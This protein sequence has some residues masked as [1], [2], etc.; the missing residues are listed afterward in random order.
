MFEPHDFFWQTPAMYFR[1]ALPALFA[2]F[3]LVSGS[4]CQKSESPA[5][6]AP[7]TVQSPDTIAWAHWVGKRRL[8]MEADSYYFSRVWSLPETARLQSQT[9]D[10]LAIGSWRLL[11]GEKAQIPGAVLRPLFDD[12]AQEE[13]YFEIRAASNSPANFLLAVHVNAHRAG[14]WETNLAI[15]ASLVTGQGP[16]PNPA[17]HGWTLQQTNAP[18]H[19]FLSRVGDWTLVAAGPG[20]NS[21]SDEIAARIRRDG[22]PFVSSGTN[23]WLETSLDLPRLAACFPALNS[24]L[25]TLN[26]LSFS[27]TGDGANVITRGQLAFSEPLPSPLAPWQMPLD[28]LHDPLTGFTAVRGLQPWLAAWQPWHDLQIGAP[29]D[30]LFLWS[31][32]GSPYQAYLAAPL[33]DAEVS[34]L[35]TWLLQKANPWLATNGY[36]TFARAADANG[37]TWGALPDIKPF[38]KSSGAGSNHWLFAGLLP[39]PRT[40]ADPPPQGLID[41]VLHRPDLVYYDWE[42]TGIRMEPDLVLGQTVRQV[43]HGTPMPMTS[44][45]LG[46]L[47]VLIPRLGTS[48]TIA[49]RTAPDQIDFYRRS[50]LGLTATELHLLADWL[51]SPQF[52]RGLHSQ[53]IP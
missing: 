15:A 10:R 8:D 42:V 52:P 13:C 44:A 39:D 12:L 38:I 46:W 35:T 48:A 2:V 22:V 43:A 21:L 24:Q 49:T 19:I 41:D 37:V 14:L 30:Q 34:A 53:S 3:I 1:P 7:P 23:L 50:T 9:F 40:A 20:Q 18:T 26:H 32:A 16:T 4:G 31:V 45:S 33:P 11:L 5:A 27:L 29:P 36:L 6:A 25:S 51:E 28:L 17:I 47:A